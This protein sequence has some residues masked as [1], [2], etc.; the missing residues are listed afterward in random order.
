MHEDDE[1]VPADKELLEGAGGVDDHGEFLQMH[2]LQSQR[3]VGLQH[4]RATFE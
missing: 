3:V 2:S 1:S 4:A